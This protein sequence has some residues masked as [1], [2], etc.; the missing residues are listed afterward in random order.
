MIESE[1]VEF[2]NKQ[3]NTIIAAEPCRSNKGTIREMCRHD[4]FADSPL[5][6]MFRGALMYTFTQITVCI[7]ANA[8]AIDCNLNAHAARVTKSKGI[9][10]RSE[11]TT[12]SACNDNSTFR[13]AVN[14]CDY[15]LDFECIGSW[16]KTPRQYV[17]LR[18]TT[19]PTETERYRCMVSSMLRCF[20]FVIVVLFSYARGH[21][22]AA[23]SASPLTLPVVSL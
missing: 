18:L 2:K 15:A 23:A 7:I 8:Q 17:A 16:K 4:Q 1:R 22:K 20:S 19:A 3:R 10:C 12:L 9:K 6:T 13:L 5:L 11:T 21:H 14:E